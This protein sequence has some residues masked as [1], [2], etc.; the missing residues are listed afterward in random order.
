[1]ADARAADIAAIEAAV[2]SLRRIHRRRALAARLA[3]RRGEWP[4]RHGQLPDAVVEL[5]AAIESAAARGETLTVSE[6]A[7]VLG[8]DQPRSSRLTAQALAAGLLRREAD[9]HDGRR[10][11][12]ALTPEGH[13]VLLRIRD[14]R[15]RV[16][17]EAI[18]DWS[19][20]DRA[21]LA[22]LLTRFLGD[23]NPG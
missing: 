15:R 16:V 22:R 19:E 23:V 12:L 8:V 6:A 20:S 14:V 9:Q 21:T 7:A 3:A 5:L 13:D 18:A 17:A 2:V 1:M 10:S 4:V 11:L